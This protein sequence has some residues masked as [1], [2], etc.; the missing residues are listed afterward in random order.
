[1]SYCINPL[2]EQRQNPNDIEKCLFCGTSL[3]IN[4]RIRL[5]KPLRALS[6]NPF[7]YTEVFEVDDAGTQWNPDRRQRVMKVLKMNS[8]KLVE[9]MERESLSLRLIHHPNIPKSTLDDFLLLFLTIVL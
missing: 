8:P 7:S 2:C 4:D 6:E 3:L 9:L 5:I 1:M